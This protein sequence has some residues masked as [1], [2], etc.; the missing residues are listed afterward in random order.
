ME[1]MEQY[2]LSAL[3]HNPS[4]ILEVDIDKED[5]QNE[6]Y[7]F[8]Y[9]N[10]KAFYQQKQNFNL[11]DFF[12]ICPDE[13][14]EHLQE[15][16]DIC[17][18]SLPSTIR[19]YALTISQAS[20]KRNILQILGGIRQ[21]MSLMDIKERLLKIESN[22]KVKSS[23]KTGEEVFNTVVNGLNM[24]AECDKTNL[25]SLDMAMGGGLYKSFV[26]GLCGQEKSG[27]T[28]LA[29]TISHN[30]DK[31]G[32]KHMYVALEMGS[33]YIEQR[34]IG[35]DIG[36]NSL[37]FL[38]NRDEIAKKIVYAKPRN[39]TFYLDAP[40]FSLNEI[41]AECSKAVMQHKIK[42]FILDYWQLVSAA[43]GRMTEEKHLRDVA[44]EIANFAKRNNIWVIILAQMNK[45]GNLFG[46]G[47]LKKACEQLYMIRTPEGYEKLRWLEM[48]AS[49]Y[50]LRVNVGSEQGPAFVMETNSGPYF[51]EI[52]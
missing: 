42:G 17:I 15:L 45:E 7:G 49:R 23:I 1:N 31:N 21:N 39:N 4:G 3:L 33:Q 44:Q 16:P 50:T 32:V 47:G 20:E 28:T 24:P 51:R 11:A 46:G 36:M 12:P 48:D 6:F 9:E 5:F 30:L 10:M 25:S 27:K 14:Y 52:K 29:H 41:L 43:D 37:S 22:E 8:I 19:D 40:G 13:Y 35:R 38:N 26:Y 2:L 34:N 18:S